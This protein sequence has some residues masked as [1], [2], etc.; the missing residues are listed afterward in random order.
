MLGRATRLCPEIHKTHFEIYDPVG[1]YDSLE[2]VNTMKPVVAN[3]TTSYAQ[4]LEGL[5]VMEDERQI[6]NQVSQIIAKI[7]RQKRNMSSELLEHFIDMI[8]GL[9]PT[10]FVGELQKTNLKSPQEAKEQLLAGR[11]LFE[12][13][14]TRE[15]HGRKIIISDAEDKLLSHER[16]Y[17][18]NSRP[19]DYLDAFAAYVQTNLNEIAA[20]N[21]VCTRPKELTRESLKSLI[22]TLD[23]EGFT[24]QQLNTAVSQMTNQEMAADMISLIRRYAIGSTLISHEARIR[25]AVDKLKK[26]HQFSKQ[27]LSWIARMEKYLMEESVLNVSVFDEDGRFKAQGG[28]TKINKV[29]QNQLENIVLELNEY[30]YDDGGKMA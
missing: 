19:E 22:L 13:L 29:F 9:D 10:Q 12:L 18:N 7:Q 14:Q 8:G 16:G 27:E 30:L 11:G 21:I 20:L 17:G 28:F 2:D 26:A 3:P 5:E 1:V 23:R 15:Y 6:Q 25:R 24:K 4:L